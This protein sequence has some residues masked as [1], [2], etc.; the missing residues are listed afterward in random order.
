M[1]GLI[2][3]GVTIYMKIANNEDMTGN[4]LLLLSVVCVLVAVQFICIGLLGEINIRTYY[5]LQRKPT[6]V[7][8]E[9]FRGGTRNGRD[10]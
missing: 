9:T 10:G 1:V 2:C 8:R 4:P 7:V 5:E 6:Y 3:L